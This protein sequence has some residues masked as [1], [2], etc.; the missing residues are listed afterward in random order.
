[1]KQIKVAK[2]KLTPTA[3]RQLDRLR[4]SQSDLHII[5]CFGR[6]FTHSNITLRT[7]EPDAAP[8]NKRL[9]RLAGITLLIVE[10]QII[11]VCIDLNEAKQ[12]STQYDDR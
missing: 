5:L 12:R 11:E 4:L 1:M 8:P 9:E 3:M 7:F 6:K 10:N 2:L